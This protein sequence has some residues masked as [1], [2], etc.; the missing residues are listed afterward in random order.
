MSIYIKMLGECGIGDD[1]LDRLFGKYG[2]RLLLSTYTQNPESLMSYEGSLLKNSCNLAENAIRIN[3][4][5]AEPIRSDEKSVMKVCLLQHIANCE[6]IVP[7]T[8]EWR[9][10]KLGEKFTYLR[11]APSIGIG[12]HSLVMA[13][14]VGIG[15]TPEEAE[16]MTIIDRT[17]DDKQAK[18]YSSMLA[19]VVRQANEMLYTQEREYRRI[20]KAGNGKKGQ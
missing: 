8:D 2:E 18:Y 6:R 3:R 4:V 9:R 11:D 7:Q 14:S 15:F 1:A 20:K 10:N 5:Y 17:E 19:V 12:L 16:A 13:T